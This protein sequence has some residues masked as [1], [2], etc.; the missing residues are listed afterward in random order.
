MNIEHPRQ[1]NEPTPASQTLKKENSNDNK[2][3]ICNLCIIIINYYF[4]K[5]I[6]IFFIPNSHPKVLIG[7]VIPLCHI[8]FLVI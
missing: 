1:I 6:D 2:C 8:L 4:S 3:H 5:T 7:I